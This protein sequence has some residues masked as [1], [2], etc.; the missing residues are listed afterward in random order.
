VAK[1]KGDSGDADRPSLTG[2]GEGL[3]HRIRTGEWPVLKIDLSDA[4]ANVR[5]RATTLRRRRIITSIVAGVMLLGLGTVLG[6][7]YVSAIPLPSQL[8]LPAT[9]TVYYSD[10]ATVMARLGSQRR[11]VV[12]T[13]TLP[14][15]IGQ[16]VVAAEDPQYWT[17]S[18]TL[19]SRQYARAATVVGGGSADS[20]T[21][22]AKLL[23]LTWKLEDS[24]SKD[25]ILGFYLNTVYFGRGAYG[26][27]AAAQTYFGVSATELSLSQAI[28]LAGM[29]A[30]PGDG[31]YDPSVDLVAASTRFATV[32]QS[33]VTMGTLDQDTAGR[34]SVPKVLPYDATTFASGLDAPTGLVVAQVLAELAG[35]DQF[36]GRP[37]SYLADGGFSIVTTI[38]VGVQHLVE[39]TVDETVHGSLLYGSPRNTQ[40]AA[41]V[42]DP[43]TGR[44]LGYFGG[45]D[46][47][48]ADYAGTYPDGAGGVAGYGYHPPAQT[49]SIYALAAALQQGISVQSRWSAPTIQ[50]FPNSGHPDTNPVRDVR[51]ADCQPVCTLAQAALTPLSIPFYTVTEK[52]GPAAVINAA[53][54]AGIGAM[55]TAGSGAAAPIRYDLTTQ[56]G[57][58]DVPKPFGADVVLGSYPVTVLD[59]ATGVATL[60]ARGVHT[61]THFVEHVTRDYAPYFTE[62][63]PSSTPT[64]D[65]NVV[66]DVTAVLADNP[67]GQLSAGPASASMAGTALIAGSALDAA[68]AWL[69]GYTPDLAAAVWV[70]NKETEFPLHDATGARI[71]GESLPAEIYRTVVG[72][73]TQA[74]GL[75]TSATFPAAAHLGDVAAGNVP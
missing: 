37:P 56:G 68:H 71:T 39:Q 55:W 35:T 12:P 4:Y 74:L 69:V 18:G 2:T 67:A 40:A 14:S 24:Y 54:D 21:D 61:P 63:G 11:T 60:A 49:M 29:I 47:T 25:Q 75:S 6:T 34:L 33:M 52:V 20:T 45:H 30:S 51:S 13:E 42:I 50:A 10:G 53:R 36:R 19:I 58:A 44:V 27:E 23:V 7:Y 22:Q 66:A 72:E 43:H 28:T 1:D 41:V 59:Q 8:T 17:T 32:A 15:Y 57:N 16:A 26:I 5:R 62:P 38:D 31:R 9:T 64:L 70:G 73:A 48:G 3:F 46:G 65:P